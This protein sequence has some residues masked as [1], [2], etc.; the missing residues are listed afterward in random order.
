[1][2]ADPPYRIEPMTLADLDEIMVL[3]NACFSAPWPRRAFRSDLKNTYARYVVLRAAG[4]SAILGY[5]GLWLIIDEAHVTTIAVHPGYRRRSLGELLLLHLFDLAAG[6]DIR[7]ITLEVRAG[8]QAAQGLYRKYG[9]R[10]EGVRRRYY[11]DTGEDALIMWS[12]DLKDPAYRRH[13]QQQR[14]AL[15]ARFHGQT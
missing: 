4:S 2:N 7:F 9:F 5:A 6:F 11:T 13:L 12:G 1:M 14:E 15:W 3:E 8:N 10:Q